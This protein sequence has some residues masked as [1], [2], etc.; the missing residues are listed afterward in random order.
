MYPVNLRR[1]AANFAS[2]VQVHIKGDEKGEAQVF[3]DRLFRAF[4]HEGTME[5]GATYEER[6]KKLDGKGT[7]IATARAL[8]SPTSSGSRSSWSG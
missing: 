1:K 2:W 3:L 4:G 8:R 6:I 7:S 5:A